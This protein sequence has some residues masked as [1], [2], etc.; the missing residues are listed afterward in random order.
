M[1]RPRM[2]PNMQF[3]L[4]LPNVPAAAIPSDKQRELELALVELLLSAA[5]ESESRSRR[6]AGHEPEVDE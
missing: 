4:L 3:T 5:H 6:G 1:K 2:L